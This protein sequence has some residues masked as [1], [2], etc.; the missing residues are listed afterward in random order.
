MTNSETCTLLAEYYPESTVMEEQKSQEH[1]RV[2][3]NVN[4]KHFKQTVSKLNIDM[5]HIQP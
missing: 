5:N 2:K 3:I 1:T 4:T